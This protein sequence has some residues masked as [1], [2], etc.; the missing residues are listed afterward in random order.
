MVEAAL[1]LSGLATVPAGDK[2][3]FVVPPKQ[4]QGL[5]RFDPARQLPGAPGLIKLVDVSPDQLLET[6]AALTGRKALPI[7]RQLPQAKFSLRSHERLSPL[8]AAYALE[9]IAA[10]NYF[11]FQ[12]VG[13]KEVKLVP[14]AETQP[15]L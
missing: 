11:A 12:P 13:E 3:V 8:E 14:L 10:L 2:F 5:P 6:Y 7:E 4:L 1:R 9:S 15:R